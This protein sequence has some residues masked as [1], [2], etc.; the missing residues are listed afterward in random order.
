MWL[1]L[2]ITRQWKWNGKKRKEG[3]PI[4]RSSAI[5]ITN[6]RLIC[7][8]DWSTT[9]YV[10]D[11]HS[12]SSY[13]WVIIMSCD[14]DGTTVAIKINFN[15]DDRQGCAFLIEPD[16]YS[17]LCRSMAVHNEDAIMHVLYDIRLP[18]SFPPKYRYTLYG[19]I[20]QVTLSKYLIEVPNYPCA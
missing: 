18:F 8:H 1:L 2:D 11:V 15:I 16:S 13:Y 14:D 10:Y 5:Q 9:S 4:K 20:H 7:M 6:R 3:N 17:L 12:S 19:S